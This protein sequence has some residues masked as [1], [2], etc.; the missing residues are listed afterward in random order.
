MDIRKERRRKKSSFYLF[1]FSFFLTLIV[2]I[3]F[4]LALLWKS[5]ADYEN[6]VPEKTMDNLAQSINQGNYDTI[7]SASGVSLSEFEESADVA[8][9]LK[10]NA[11]GKSVTYSR[12]PGGT[13]Q[14]MQFIMSSGNDELATVTVKM[15]PQ[16][17]KFGHDQYEIESIAGKMKES[18]SVEITAP[19]TAKIF[20]NE[21]EVGEKYIAQKDIPFTQLQKLPDSFEKPTMV[22]YKIDNIYFE[23][24]VSAKGYLG[25]EL[26][27][28]R[29]TK[30]GAYNVSADGTA[31]LSTQYSKLAINVAQTYA[32]FVTNDA[33]FTELS[34]YISRETSLYKKLSALEVQFYADH[35]KYEFQDIKTSDFMMYNDNCFSIRVKFTH[36]VYRTNRDKKFEFPSDFTFCFVKKNGNWLVGD[37]TIN[38]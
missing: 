18:Q 17:S 10:K 20:V 31:D 21:R 4:A 15:K 14:R 30:T 19:S 33:T 26:S 9:Y 16:K 7:A 37:M 11:E 6:C 12:K 38:S 22:K 32:K 8:D 29:D 34:K 36:I 23:P 5:M 25:N 28:V 24:A 35:D 1:Y 2:L 3:L 27:V 13:A